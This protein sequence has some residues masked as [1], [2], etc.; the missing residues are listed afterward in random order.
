MVDNY[1]FPP[2][3]FSLFWPL[4][5]GE[6]YSNL[7]LMRVHKG[8]GAGERGG[9][10]CASQTNGAGEEK[11]RLSSLS[12]PVLVPLSLFSFPPF[13]WTAGLLSNRYK[14]IVTK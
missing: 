1:F 8:G 10:I 3:L 11:L 7:H 12:F 9:A 6:T 2:V 13:P 5:A 14:Q 4:G